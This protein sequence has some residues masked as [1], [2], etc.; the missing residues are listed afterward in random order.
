MGSQVAQK[1]WV[2]W[3]PTAYNRQLK[4]GASESCGTEPLMC[5]ILVVSIRTELNCWTSSWY[6][7]IGWHGKKMTHL[8]SEVLCVRIKENT[9]LF[10]WDTFPELWQ[11]RLLGNIS[12]HQFSSVIQS[13]PTL[14]D[15]V[16][17]ST[18][19]LPVHHQL[20]QFTQT[21]AHWVGDAIQLSHP[22][23]SSSPPTFNYSQHQGLFQGVSSSHQVTKVLE[24][25]LQHQSFPWSLRTDLL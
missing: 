5:G 2:I 14:F 19:G 12:P 1:L 4:G 7:R 8:V 25:Q 22:L 23:L 13:C 15:P 9:R 11:E 18:P 21:H 17:C 20:P 6:W 10:S 24:F 16:D 3:G